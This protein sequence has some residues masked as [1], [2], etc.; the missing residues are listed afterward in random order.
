VFVSI[1]GGQS[2]PDFCAAFTQK[3]YDCRY[4]MCRNSAGPAANNNNHCQHAVGMIE[5]VD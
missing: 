5:C 3:Q 1:P 4:T 2:C